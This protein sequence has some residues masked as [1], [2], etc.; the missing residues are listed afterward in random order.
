MLFRSGDLQA[1]FREVGVNRVTLTKLDETRFY[2]GLLNAP[3]RVGRPLAYIADGPGMP[4][5]IAVADPRLVSEFLL[6]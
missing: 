1:A 5:A 6:P 3:M 2:G 4:D